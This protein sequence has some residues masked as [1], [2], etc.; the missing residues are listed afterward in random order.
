MRRVHRENPKW[1]T[2]EDFSSGFN[3]ST[4][5]AIGLD[6]GSKPIE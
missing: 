2:D 1:G 5:A 4:T 6:A 3:Y